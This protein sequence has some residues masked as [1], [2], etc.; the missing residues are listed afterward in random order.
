M[1]N[2]NIK[3]LIILT[4]GFFL[5]GCQ[6]KEKTIE[7]KDFF[8]TIY[9]KVDSDC[10]KEIELYYT[11]SNNVKYYSSCLSEI[12]LKINNQEISL[13]DAIKEDPR[14]MEEILSKLTIT[15]VA[16]DGGTTIYKDFGYSGVAYSELGNT[17]FTI[18]KCNS[19]HSKLNEEHP[20]VEYN[21]DYYFGDIHL[22]YEE[23]FCGILN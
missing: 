6:V 4:I 8:Q 22:D 19:M 14:I 5:T 11:D 18:I 20:S 13:K 16:M 12:T 7:E 9:F 21:K 3:L 23:G 1:N 17:G 10:N 15:D 2:K